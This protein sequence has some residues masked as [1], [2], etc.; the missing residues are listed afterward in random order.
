MAK[1]VAFW[2]KRT[3]VL[4]QILGVTTFGVLEIPVKLDTYSL[5]AVMPIIIARPPHRM[6]VK[7]HDGDRQFSHSR[8]SIC[9]TVASKCA[10]GW[11]RHG[12]VSTHEERSLP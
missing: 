5:R 1:L 8:M 12:V 11:E 2:H 9:A 7:V 10:D 6:G 4:V 3:N